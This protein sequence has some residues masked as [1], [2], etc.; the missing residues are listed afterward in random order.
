MVKRLSNLEMAEILLPENINIA[1]KVRSTEV[2]LWRNTKKI[3]NPLT[4][5]TR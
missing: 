3:N 2:G 4:R 5:S 1:G